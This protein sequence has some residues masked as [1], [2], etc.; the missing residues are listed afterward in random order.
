ML[1]RTA[2]LLLASG[3]L[4]AAGA[5]ETASYPSR[6]IHIV[7]PYP[8][9]GSADLV[10][11]MVAQKLAQSMGQP[12]V[13]DNKAGASGSIGSDFVSRAMPDG[14]TLLVAI[15]DTHAI[16]PAVMSNL[17]YDPQ[18]DFVP[19]SLMATQPMVLAVGR[20]MPARTLGEF[21]ALAKQKPR[22][23]SYA[24]NGKGGLQH[25]A[26]ELFSRSAGIETLH[27]PYKGAAPAI[28]DVIG[29]QVNALFISLQGAGSNIGSSGNLRPLAI[30]SQ[31]R[32]AV[33]ADVPTFAEAGYPQFTVTQWYG[34]MAPKGT[35]AAIVDRLNREVKAALAA[36]DVSDKLKA[37]GTEPVG[38]SPE[39]FSIFLASEIK[40]WADVAQSV[41]ARLE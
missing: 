2:L 24:S 28:A 22:G 36:P 15:S 13:I 25:L 14:Y 41:G 1:R 30:A 9:G 21:V 31:K 12:V 29:G 17:P 26:M 35:P 4:S 7:V 5:A 3:L 37:A 20:S 10:G 27:V 34:L 11:R 18:K 8:P 23:V 40:K 19:V 32:L 6:P 33:A 39:Q 16:N 38:G